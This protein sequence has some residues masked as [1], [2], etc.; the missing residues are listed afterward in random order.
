M[1][2][3]EMDIIKTKEKSTDSLAFKATKGLQGARERKI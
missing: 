3:P 2:N 1:Q